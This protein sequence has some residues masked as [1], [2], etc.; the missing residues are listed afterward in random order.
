[1]C[2]FL[3]YGDL[4]WPFLHCKCILHKDKLFLYVFPQL[5]FIQMNKVTQQTI[6][7]FYAEKINEK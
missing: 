2:Y 3:C 1:M 6:G 5:F 4:I 7:L